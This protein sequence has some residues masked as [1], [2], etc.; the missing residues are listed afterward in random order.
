[1]AK[2]IDA[3]YTDDPK[4]NPNAKRLDEITY[5]DVL[6]KGLKAL[7]WTAASF[8]LENNLVIR[9]FGLDDPENI[10]RVITGEKIGTVLKK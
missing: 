9:M 6:N 3:V 4:K 8:G 5:T 2:N 10:I 7:D 1:M